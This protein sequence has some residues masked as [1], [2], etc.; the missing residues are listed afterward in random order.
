MVE[1]ILQSRFS[2]IKILFY[3]NVLFSIFYLYAYGFK[4][5]YLWIVLGIFFFMNPLG[6]A[7]SYHR[8]WSH[9]AFE[10]KNNFFMYLCTLPPM[11]SGV[12]SILGWVGIHRQHHKHSDSDVDPHKASK[13]LMSMLSMQSYNYIPKPK[14]VIDLMRD[15][16]ILWTHKYYFTFPLVFAILMLSLFGIH[17]L[18]IGFC[19]PSAL[20]M[21]TQNTT[22]F[23][24]HF[25][26]DKYTPTNIAWINL[27][28]FGDGWHKNH[29][30]NPR[31]YTT[32]QKWYEID[33]AG[34]LIKYVFAKTIVT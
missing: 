17:G 3:I 24:N 22:N 33:F 11:I 27:F 30:D 15:P 13:G 8:Y 2:V 16:F 7:V 12:G 28:N 20:S 21:L 18:A 10:F 9:R 25:G 34:I 14:E 19:M 29:H 1:N 5:D 31:R 6:I 32:Q 26:K 4:I 23:V